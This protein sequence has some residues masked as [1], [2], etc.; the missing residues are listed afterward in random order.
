MDRIF[1][2]NHATANYTDLCRL[3]EEENLP[4]SQMLESKWLAKCLLNFIS[5]NKGRVAALYELL[6]IFTSKTRVSFHFLKSFLADRVA[7]EYS[8]EEQ[9]K[10]I[11]FSP[12]SILLCLICL[13]DTMPHYRLHDC[14]PILF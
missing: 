4:R 3:A 9:K 10:V 13:F 5:R 1:S 8:I 7:Q 11:P 2:K 12:Y 6:S 14:L